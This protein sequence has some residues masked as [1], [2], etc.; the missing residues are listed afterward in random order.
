MVESK[1]IFI[2]EVIP[3]SLNTHLAVFGRENFPISQSQRHVIGSSLMEIFENHQKEVTKAG[4]VLHP[5]VLLYPQGRIR[6]VALR[7]LY[8]IAE[9]TQL[10][11]LADVNVRWVAVEEPLP[12]GNFPDIFNQHEMRRLSDLGKRLGRDPQSWNSSSP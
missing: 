12:D 1:E 8:S 2:M 6:V 9:L 10:R 5:A 11:G 3:Q 4:Q 7:E